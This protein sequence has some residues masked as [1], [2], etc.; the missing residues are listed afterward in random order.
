MNG[1]PAYELDFY[2]WTQQQARFL[3]EEKWSR[4]YEFCRGGFHQQPI[5]SQEQLM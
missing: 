4:K 5:N 1:V 2:A 3:Q